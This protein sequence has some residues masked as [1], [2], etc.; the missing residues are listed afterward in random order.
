MTYCSVLRFQAQL[1][2]THSKRW[3][4]LTSDTNHTYHRWYCHSTRTPYVQKPPNTYA[5][6]S[7]TNLP[8]TFPLRNFSTASGIFAKGKTS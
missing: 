1:V 2:S 6:K 8:A 7:T 4:L 5:L 3:E